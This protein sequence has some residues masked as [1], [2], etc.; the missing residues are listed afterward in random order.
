MKKIVFFLVFLI[1]R[2]FRFTY[3]YRLI[4]EHHCDKARKLSKYNNFLISAWHQDLMAN[5]T[6]NY[7]RNFCSMAS[8]SKDGDIGAWVGKRWGYVVTRGS[9]SRGGK[10]AMSEMIHALKKGHPGALTVDGPRG[11]RYVVKWGIIEMAKHTQAPIIPVSSYASSMWV[12]HKS[13]DKFR[14][15]KPF[16][17]VYIRYGEPIL[18]PN[19]ISDE[20]KNKLAL[21]IAEKMIQGEQELKNKFNLV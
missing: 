1:I 15:P 17:K 12:F 14:L 20:D 19:D 5:F 7:K 9:S 18:V 6:V 10:E 8:R 13:W 11:P 3:R 4:D 21:D 2:F 16:S